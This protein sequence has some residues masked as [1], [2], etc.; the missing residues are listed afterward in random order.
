MER[1][2]SVAHAPDRSATGAGGTSVN[3]PVWLSAANCA[4][5][6]GGRPEVVATVTLPEFARDWAKRKVLQALGDGAGRNIDEI[7]ASVKDDPPRSWELTD[8]ETAVDALLDEDL[9]EKVTTGAHF[10]NKM[11][12]PVLYVISQLGRAR[13]QPRRHT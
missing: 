1:R 2:L 6:A 12:I 7:F 11:E 8:V 3:P 9:I 4:T 10:G 5:V 13:L